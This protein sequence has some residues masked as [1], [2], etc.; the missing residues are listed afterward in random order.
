MKN[1]SFL[2]AIF[3]I[4]VSTFGQTTEVEK[5]LEARYPIRIKSFT[6]RHGSGGD[7]KYHG[8]DGI[9]REI[10]FLEP[11]HVSLLTGRRNYAPYGLLGGEPGLKGLNILKRAGQEGEELPWAAAF[12]VER[13]DILIIKTPGGGGYGRSD[14]RFV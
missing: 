14:P 3:F 11:L 4:T 2:I 8:G 5:I 7:G 12:K 9:T 10:E 13:G 6:I 1:F